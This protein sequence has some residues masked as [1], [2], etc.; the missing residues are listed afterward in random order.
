MIKV[1]PP[2]GDETRD[3]PPFFNDEPDKNK[4]LYFWYY[5]T[6]KK[7]VTSDLRADE[8]RSLFRKLAAKADVIVDSFPPGLLADLGIGYE[9]IRQI[10]PNIIMA[11]ISPFGQDTPYSHY[12][13]TDLTALAFGGPV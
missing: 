9:A 11:A 4:S 13:A 1:E 7:S 10:C 5:G 2:M 6:N 12:V 8:G 3:C